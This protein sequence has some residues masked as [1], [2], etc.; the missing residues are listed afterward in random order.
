M[1]R[2]ILGVDDKIELNRRMSETLEEML[3]VL[4]E[5]WFVAFAAGPAA[6]SRSQ[7]EGGA[8]PDGWRLGTLGDVA[9]DVRCSVN[10]S[11]L[12]PSR[13][14]GGRFVTEYYELRQ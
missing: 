12:D 13:V 1:C 9:V 11:G 7:E 8:Y 5:A 6:D 4:H 2:F 10:P 14:N 3:R